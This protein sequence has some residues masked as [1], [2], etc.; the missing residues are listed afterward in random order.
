MN[1]HKETFIARLLIVF[2]TV[3]ALSVAFVGL[4]GMARAQS[5][6]SAKALVPTPFSTAYYGLG[7]GDCFYNGSFDA[8]NNPSGVPL[9]DTNMVVKAS[10]VGLN[11]PPESSCNPNG[12]QNSTLDVLHE[13]RDKIDIG[14]FATFYIFQSDAGG[15]GSGW[16]AAHINSGCH[17]VSSISITDSLHGSAEGGIDPNGKL[18]CAPGWES[19][20]MVD[21]ESGSTLTATV[22]LDF[23]AQQSA[24]VAV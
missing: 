7:K 3:L 10:C 1:T 19:S 5:A 22:I 15:C 11:P 6:V 14:G 2:C 24:S 23:Q 9:A 18:I 8:V 13:V 4:A 12:I 20:K 17:V 21:A 16:S